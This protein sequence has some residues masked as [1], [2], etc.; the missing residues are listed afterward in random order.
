[1][2]QEPAANFEIIIDHLKR[3][4][5]FQERYVDTDDFFKYVEESNY[6][7][8]YKSRFGQYYLEKLLEHYISMK[9]LNINSDDI[10]IDIAAD[11]SY[12][13]ENMQKKYGIEAY[14]QDRI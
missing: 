13:A 10:L 6:P 7:D 2:Q 12:F 14:R 11:Q 8:S 4:F 5:Q 9:L 3:N 1:M